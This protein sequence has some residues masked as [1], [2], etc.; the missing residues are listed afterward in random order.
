MK[1]CENGVKN[2]V[3]MKF[4]RMHYERV[5]KLLRIRIAIENV[6]RALDKL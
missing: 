4:G 1:G 3:G 6:L 5:R 2:I